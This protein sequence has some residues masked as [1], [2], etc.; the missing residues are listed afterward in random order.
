MEKTENSTIS[1]QHPEVW[2]MTVRI[3]KNSLAYSLHSRM[4]ENSLSYGIFDLEANSPEWIKQVEA[5]VYDNGFFLYDYERIDFLVES[6][7]FIVVPN[8]FRDGDFDKC[9]EYFKFL[10]PEDKGT[11]MVDTLPDVGA[12]I[13][14]S[15][16]SDLDSFL[17][18]TFDNPPI[19]HI[20]TPMIKFF[21]RKDVYGAERKM[22]AYLTGEKVEIVAL[23]NGKMLFANYFEYS[24]L[25]DAFFYI[26]NAWKTVGMGADDELHILGDKEDRRTLLPKL[27]TYI[28]TVIQTI[29]PAQLLRLGKNAMSA[30]FDLIVLPLCE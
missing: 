16:P 21:R 19:S 28:Q 27:R 22:Y 9:E 17:R 5:V 20:L 12:V 4:E 26:M 1:I 23:Q 10:Y 30:P 8:D 11:I 14:Y 15:I 2:R 3:N 24:N 6:N 25:E 29:F 18:R 7:H 13:V